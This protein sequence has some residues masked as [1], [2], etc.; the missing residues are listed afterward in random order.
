[1]IYKS[2]KM[3]HLLG[4]ALFLGSVFGH[5]ATGVLAGPAGGSPGFIAARENIQALTSALTLPG[6]GLA[7]LSGLGMTIAARIN[8]LRAR[9]LALH[10][11]LALAIVVLTVS[12]VAPAGRRVL[13]GAL[14]A[15]SGAA[16]LSGLQ[17]DLLAEH[18][19]GS[20][21]VALALA[22][23]AAAVLRPRLARRKSATS[24]NSRDNA[25]LISSRPTARN[26]EDTTP[27]SP[28]P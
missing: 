21:N 1:M 6:V 25:A 11:T 28:A 5:I 14:A 15:R 20:V 16:T 10:G 8:P 3:L 13:A 7:L 12:V 22:A 19:F 9:W 24:K 26:S 2:F 4:F 23:L 27:N 18:V 17:A